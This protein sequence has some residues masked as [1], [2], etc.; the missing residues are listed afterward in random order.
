[1]LNTLIARFRLYRALRPRRTG[2]PPLTTHCLIAL[3]RPAARA[4]LRSR[5]ITDVRALGP[6][7]P[8]QFSG[9]SEHGG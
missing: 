4:W 3:Q 2:P 9:G 8:P 7:N 6:S 1:M 5:G